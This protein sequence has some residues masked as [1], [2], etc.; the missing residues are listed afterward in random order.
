MTRIDL[1]D[2]AAIRREG[3][4]WPWRIAFLLFGVFLLIATHW[5]GSDQPS[6]GHE[7]PDK[8]L[9]FLCFGG[10]AFLLWMTDWIRRFWIVSILAIG[11]TI[12]DELTQSFFSINREASGA[13]IAAGILGVLTASAW[14]STFNSAEQL[15]TRQQD[16]RL[17]Y[18]L[19]EML[20]RP[21][22]W[23]L[24][25]AAFALPMVLLFVVIYFLTWNFLGFSISN[26][27]LTIGVVAGMAVALGMLL[28]LAPPFI[29]SVEVNHPCFDCG[30]SLVDLELDEHGLG[31]CTSCGHPVHASQWH[32]LPAPNIPVSVLLSTDGPLGFACML[33]YLVLAII[34]G[35]LLLLASGHAGL[36]TAI[37]YTGI[38]IA[39]AMF[40]QWYRIQRTV[41]LNQGGD[42]CIRCSVDIAAIE[43]EGGIGHC[44][45]CKA[46]FARSRSSVDDEQNSDRT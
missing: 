46:I 27:A 8:L 45:N 34:A 10:L 29:E 37:F 31:H 15:V 22:N 9:H 26:I 7:S 20:A 18:I 43:A 1:S 41:I 13:D 28:R 39:G 42:R 36:A 17:H 32:Q 11:F 12:L 2:P 30:A 25:G 3:A 23:F 44:P 38:G 5:P 19:D 21:A 6:S 16:R 14:M 35:P 24:L 40:W 33:C 4:A